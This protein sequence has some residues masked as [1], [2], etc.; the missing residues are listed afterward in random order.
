MTAM[1]SKEEKIESHERALRRYFQAAVR[2]VEENKRRAKRFITCIDCT[3]T[4]WDDFVVYDEIWNSVAGRTEG[5]L[6]LSCLEKRLGRLLKLGDFTDFPVNNMLKL[7]YSI[8][9]RQ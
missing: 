7:G 4:N 6:H 3:E 1:L 5:R 9:I 2:R 8:G